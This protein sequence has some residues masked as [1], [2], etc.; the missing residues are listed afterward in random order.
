MADVFRFVSVYIFPCVE[1]E[2]ISQTSPLAVVDVEEHRNLLAETYGKDA[3]DAVLP[4]A[5]AELWLG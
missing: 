5:A 4:R 1:A 2:R 3:P